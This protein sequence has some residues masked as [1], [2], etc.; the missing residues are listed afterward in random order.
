MAT[1]TQHTLPIE[2][3]K[4]Q[5]RTWISAAAVHLSSIIYN[6]GKWFPTISVVC[7]SAQLTN[8]VLLV[9]LRMVIKGPAV[10][11]TN[12][13]ETRHSFWRFAILSKYNG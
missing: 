1:D 2:L 13:T 8:E 10:S 9:V 6:A 7:P 11:N 12:G 3:H 5:S 4:L